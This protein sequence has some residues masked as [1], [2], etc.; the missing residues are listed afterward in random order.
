[1]RGRRVSCDATLCEPVGNGTVALRR[2]T[3]APEKCAAARKNRDD[4]EVRVWICS[5]A[6]SSD[7][8]RTSKTRSRDLAAH[9]QFLQRTPSRRQP[10]HHH[11][12]LPDQHLRHREPGLHRETMPGL[13]SIVSVGQTPN[14]FK[15]LS[16]SRKTARLQRLL[17]SVAAVRVL[18]ERIVGT[19]SSAAS[20]THVQDPRRDRSRRGV[21]QTRQGSASHPVE[22]A[23]PGPANLACPR[24]HVTEV[25]SPR[26]WLSHQSVRSRSHRHHDP[27]P[28][29]REQSR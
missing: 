22:S 26:P 15:Q 28:V 2:K 3:V 11:C 29:D 5:N 23:R 27:D 21:K 6:D 19:A 8:G 9:S 12:P 18:A 10:L 1:M 25:T 16:M 13:R 20:A 14:S 4:N 17:A 24:E 7:A